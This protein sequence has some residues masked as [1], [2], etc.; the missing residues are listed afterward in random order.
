MNSIHSSRFGK[1]I[2][3]RF[4]GGA[5]DE[6]GII[7]YLLEKCRVAQHAEGERN[8]HIFYQLIAATID[9]TEFAKYLGMTNSNVDYAYARR[10]EVGS[11]AT[12]NDL[13]GFHEVTQA[14]K[15]LGISDTE[16]KS[17]YRVVAGV[18]L[19]GNVGKLK[20]SLF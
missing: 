6:A 15:V 1:L 2:T 13:E 11:V 5:I 17:I 7:S 3:L 19:L 18:L 4:S 12:I 10:D 14:L 8:F 16:R 9:D 20:I